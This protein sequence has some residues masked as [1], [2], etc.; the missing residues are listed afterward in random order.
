MALQLGATIKGSAQLLGKKM[1]QVAVGK[2]ED[3]QT[4]QRVFVFWHRFK[5]L[6]MGSLTTSFSIQLIYAVQLQD[7]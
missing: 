3:G 4:I 1:S 5:V 2:T 6:A 7:N